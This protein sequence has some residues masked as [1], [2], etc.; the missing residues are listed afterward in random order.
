MSGNSYQTLIVQR[1][2]SNHARGAD[3][4]KGAKGKPYPVQVPLSEK[5]AETLQKVSEAT[6]LPQEILAAEAIRRGI[7]ALNAHTNNQ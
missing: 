4:A 3:S 2:V 5:T 6:R 7:G 1:S